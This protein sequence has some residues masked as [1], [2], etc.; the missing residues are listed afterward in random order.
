MIRNYY[1]HTQQI[2]PRRREEEPQTFTVTRHPKDNK[3]KATNSRFLVKMITKLERTQSYK[4]QN[5]EKHRTP[6]NNG[7]YIKHKINNSYATGGG[8]CLN[9]FYWRKIFA[10]NSVAKI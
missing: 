1:N 4:Y 9:A 3:S 5:K 7:R 10:L 8:G 2:N 6:T